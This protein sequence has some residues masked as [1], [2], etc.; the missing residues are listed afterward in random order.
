MNI[1]KGIKTAT[2]AAAIYATTTL[3]GLEVMAQETVPA[4]TK[5]A[6]VEKAKSSQPKFTV[7]LTEI[8]AADPIHR[9]EVMGSNLPI[10]GDFYGVVEHNLYAGGDCYKLRL[11]AMP[12]TGP[13][14]SVGVAG[15]YAGLMGKSSSTDLGAV[16]RYQNKMP[17][18][19]LKADVRYFPGTHTLDHYAIWDTK[20]I[21]V[22]SLG[23]Y[24]TETGKWSERLGV[25]YKIAPSLSLGLE[26][27]VDGTRQGTTGRY[28][29]VRASVK[30]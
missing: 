22:D 30:F 16:L 26:G 13:H 14:F 6:V 15:Q 11:Q 17:G 19:N 4:P 23:A 27:R 3:G 29:G 24:N 9:A 7:K 2:I 25:D 5:P 18:S 28:A 1:Y 20:M 10:N 8:G 21:F 12:I